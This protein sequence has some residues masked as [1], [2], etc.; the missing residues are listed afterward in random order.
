[1]RSLEVDA[2]V[3]TSSVAKLLDYVKYFSSFLYRQA[4]ARPVGSRW[5]KLSLAA[6]CALQP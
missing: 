6:Y 3:A 1:M 4:A 2:M 5:H